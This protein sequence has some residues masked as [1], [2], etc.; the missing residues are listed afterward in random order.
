[1]TFANNDTLNRYT[2]G[3]SPNIIIEQSVKQAWDDTKDHNS[4][5][6]FIHMISGKQKFGP[7]KAKKL[8]FG[9]GDYFSTSAALSVAFAHN[10]TQITLTENRFFTGDVLRLWDTTAPNANKYALI[11][12]GSQVGDT[13]KFNCTV[14]QTNST[15]TFATA[16]TQV[17]VLHSA[18][19][20]DGKAR[21]Y[22][23]K[24]GD[25]GLNW[26]QRGRDTVGMGKAEQ[27]EDF[28]IDHSMET[29]V[30]KAWRFYILKKNLALYFN[31]VARGGVNETNEWQLSGGLPYFFNPTSA[32]FSESGG[33]RNKAAESFGGVNKVI[34]GTN[35]TYSGLRQWFYD[36]T[37]YGS[38]NK[39]VTM[40]YATYDRFIE[41][42]KNNVQVTDK[43]LKMLVP[44]MPSPWL[45]PTV[46]LGGAMVHIMVDRSIDGSYMPIT[47]G[48]DTADPDKWM[49]AI[50]P[51]HIAYVPLIMK[52]KVMTPHLAYIDSIENDSVETAEY[53]S[54]DGL[55]IDEPRSGGYCG[56][57]T[58]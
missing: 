34:S 46:E 49:V 5:L 55:V 7:K 14:L 24:K 2:L 31:S 22:L 9:I 50:D 4:L 16:T 21:P 38:K 20:N 35:F 58:T 27:S 44:S 19:S 32:A 10:A 43:D 39:V 25:L 40:P 18:V 52:D 6:S 26:M 47:V 36:M 12:L 41:L 56:L 13:P 53:D 33:I 8:H 51:E 28:I 17:I 29:L 3:T 54:F 1:M 57:K 42:L 48:S 23:N 11:R 45:V 15:G 30:Q 37:L